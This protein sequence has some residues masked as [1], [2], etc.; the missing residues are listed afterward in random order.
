MENGDKYR[1]EVNFMKDAFDFLKSLDNKTQEKILENIRISRIR[2]DPKLLKKVDNDI[3]EFRSK[4][5]SNQI[6]L[7]AFWD[8]EVKSLIVCTHGFVKKTQK[9]PKKELNKAK[10]IRKLYLENKR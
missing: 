7:L 6:R 8:K 4:F 2:T 5:R 3:W 10:R 1:F 9:L